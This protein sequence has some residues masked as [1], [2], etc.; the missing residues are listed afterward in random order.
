MKNDIWY[1]V[2]KY[3]LQHSKNEEMMHDVLIA[4]LQEFQVKSVKKYLNENWRI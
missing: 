2:L 1:A 3:L 4:A